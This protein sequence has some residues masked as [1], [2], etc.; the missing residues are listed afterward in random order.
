MLSYHTGVL[1]TAIQI[2][3]SLGRVSNR[4]FHRPEF[5]Y[6]CLIFIYVFIYVFLS[7]HSLG[8]AAQL[9]VP[10]LGL[11][12]PVWQMWGT[13]GLKLKQNR[14]LHIR[15]SHRIWKCNP[16]LLLLSSCVVSSKKPSTGPRSSDAF[17]KCT[18][19]V[20]FSLSHWFQGLQ[21][22]FLIHWVGSLDV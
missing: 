11:R 1:A 3:H 15:K 20:I 16:D 17:L 9:A 5:P 2:C 6:I 12:D 13:S 21:V 14:D 18:P 22:A 10:A 7:A 19:K 8:G 4:N